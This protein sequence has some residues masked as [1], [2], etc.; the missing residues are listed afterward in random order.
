MELK[1]NIYKIYFIFTM[2]TL[3][4]KSSS[5]N[6]SAVASRMNSATPINKINVNTIKTQLRKMVHSHC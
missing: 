3:T 4:S 5:P 1:E 2:Y 6:T